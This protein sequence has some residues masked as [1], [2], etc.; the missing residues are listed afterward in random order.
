[1]KKAEILRHLTEWQRVQKN[2]FDEKDKAWDLT[3]YDTLWSATLAVAQAHTDAVGL[4]IGDTLNFMD[5]WRKDCEFGDNPLSVWM[6]GKDR[7]IKTL[8]Q[9]AELIAG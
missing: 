9:L 3:Y 8:R 6:G 1:M 4:I 2:L 7:K 5:W